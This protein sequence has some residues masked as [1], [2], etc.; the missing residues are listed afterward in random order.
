MSDNEYLLK[1][2]FS[3][4]FNQNKYVLTLNLNLKI[5]FGV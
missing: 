5:L 1:C 4:I 3:Y 2:K